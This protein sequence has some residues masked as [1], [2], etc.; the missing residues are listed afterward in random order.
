MHECLRGGMFHYRLS[1]FGSPVEAGDFLSFAFFDRATD[2]DSF[3][4]AF[5]VKYCKK[6][7]KGRIK[8]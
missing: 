2:F 6:K 5:V 1:L 7:E 4:V 8:K 3:C